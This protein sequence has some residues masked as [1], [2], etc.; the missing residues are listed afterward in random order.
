MQNKEFTLTSYQTYFAKAVIRMTALR[1]KKIK[2]KFVAFQYYL[3][4]E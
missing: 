2:I 3:F 1:S 4:P